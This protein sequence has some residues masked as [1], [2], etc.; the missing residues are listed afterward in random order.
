[1][2]EFK[3]NFVLDVT[4]VVEHED[5]SATITFDMDDS[6]KHLLI[7][8]AITDILKKAAAQTKKEQNAD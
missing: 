1:M 8:Y 6:S 2:D 3:M 4:Q 5:G 7:Q